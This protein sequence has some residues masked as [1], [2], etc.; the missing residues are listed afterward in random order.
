MRSA[1]GAMAARQDTGA[2]PTVSDA[3]V[4]DMLRSATRGPEPV[5]TAGTTLEGTNVTG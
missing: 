3:C 2:S 1:S 4:M 5:S